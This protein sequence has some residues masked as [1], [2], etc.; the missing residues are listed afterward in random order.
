MTRQRFISAMLFI[1]LTLVLVISQRCSNDNDE[2]ETPS[3]IWNI[4]NDGL[5]QFVETNYIELDK[6]Y[7]I[8]KFRSSVG[9]DYSD[10]T[11]QCR[12]M[13]HYFEPLSNVDWASIKIVAPVKGTI[14]RIDTE[15]AGVKIEI[16][17]EAYPAFRF[18]IFHVAPMTSFEVGEKV[19]AGQQL[20]NHIGFQTM[21][22]ISVIV[23]DPT[24]QGRM[25][26]FFEVI[27]TAVFND[28]ALRG[29]T[30]K[31]ELIISKE[32]RDSN[33]LTC[34]GDAFSS[35]DALESWFVLSD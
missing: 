31:N 18:S 22:D 7:R 29:V 30:N 14:T 4:D 16:Q 1:V 5:P 23:N 26:S 32:I 12:S 8:S 11:E 13:K 33:P 20:G 35:N 21:S 6:I 28:Y 2:P 15:W 25:V 24:R 3:D 19:I 9:H 27:T 17:S 10:A 34:N